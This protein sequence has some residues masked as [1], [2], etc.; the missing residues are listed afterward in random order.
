MPEIDMKPMDSSMISA[1]G[2]DEETRVLRIEFKSDGAVI[3]YEGVEPGVGNGL[4]TAASA[5]RFWNTFIKSKSYRW[6]KV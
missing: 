2:Y 3:E 5:G 6:R 1:A 4:L